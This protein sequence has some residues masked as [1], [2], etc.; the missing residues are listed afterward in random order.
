MCIY[1]HYISVIVVVS[2]RPLNFRVHMYWCVC[3]R[4]VVW[5]VSGRAALVHKKKHRR[6]LPSVFGH[7]FGPT[8]R[9]IFYD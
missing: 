8:K 1:F 2:F 6:C 5:F 9:N 4:L 7:I 3:V